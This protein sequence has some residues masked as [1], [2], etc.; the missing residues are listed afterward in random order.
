V[1]T[2]S[3]LS[4][5]AD[6]S[7]NTIY[8]SNSIDGSGI[9]GISLSPDYTNVEIDLSDSS[10]PYEVSA[11]SIYAY[12]IYLLTTQQGIANFFGAITPID[13]MNYQINAAVAPLRF[14][15]TGTSHVVI[16]G[17]RI[18]RDDNV[19][20]IN[21]S[22]NTGSIVHDTGFLVQFLQPQ[23][24]AAFAGY[25]VASSSGMDAMESRLKKKINQA[26][27]I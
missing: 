23:V 21:T 12:Y 25:G 24:E 11:Q 4:F 22:S 13:R 17:G 19:S 8:N 9:S 20:I 1:A 5:R 15:N 16:N 26:V 6:Q 10:A 2:A 18:F 27:L 7:L 3:G 14:Q